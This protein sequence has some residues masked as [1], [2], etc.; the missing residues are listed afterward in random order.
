MVNS[1]CLRKG[2]ARR[3]MA[4][5]M[6]LCVLMG[7][8]PSALSAESVGNSPDSLTRSE[9]KYFVQVP[10]SGAVFFTG[11]TYGTGTQVTVAAGT[12][13]Q[14]VTDNYY[15]V[16]DASNV[17]T[18]YYGVFY[19]NVQ[20]QVRCSDVS[21]LSEEQLTTYIENFIWKAGTHSTLKQELNLV[22]DVRVYALQLALKQLGYYSSILDGDYGQKTD[23]AVY[24]FQR[25]AKLSRDGDAGPITQAALYSQVLNASGGSGSTGSGSSGNNSGS[26]SSGSGSS[27]SGSTGS[28]GSGSSGSSANT[29]TLVTVASVNLREKASKDSPRL[30]VV[31]TNTS[32]PYFDTSSSGNV[33]WYKVVYEEQIGWL[34]GTFV[35]ATGSNGSTGGG[36]GSGSGSGSSSTVPGNSLKTTDSV[37][38]RKTPSTSAAKLDVIPKGV[39]LAYTEVKNVNNVNWY[40]VTYGKNTGWIMGT[41]TSMGS[42]STGGSGSGSGSAGTDSTT[43]TGKVTITKKGTVVRLTPG[44]K[45]S[46]TLLSIGSVVDMLGSPVTS[47]SY[48]WYKIKLSNG[49]IGYVRG[50]CAKITNTGNTVPSGNGPATSKKFITLP[51]ATDLYLT[52]GAADGMVS[53]PA[54]S[55][56]MMVDVKPYTGNDGVEYC[57]LYY[58]GKAYHVEYARVSAGLMDDKALAAHVMGIWN[59]PLNDKF[60]NDG[61]LVGDVRVFAMQVALRVLGYYTGELDG[62]YGSGSEAAV[63]NFQRKKKVERDGVMGDQTWPLLTAQAKQVSDGSTTYSPNGDS[64]SGSG[65]VT[66]PD[67]GTV[68]KVK[69]ASWD[70]DDNGAQLFPKSTTATVMD[71]ETGKVFTIYRWSGGNHADCVPL[72]TADTQIMC[73]IAGAK[74]QSQKPTSAQLQKIKNDIIN[75]NANYCW[76]DFN[77]N[78]GGTNIGSAWDR[79]AA[80]LNVNGTVYCVSIYGYPHGWMDIKNGQPVASSFTNRKFEEKNN[81]YGM[82]CIHFVGSKTHGGSAVDSAHNNAINKAYSEAKKRWGNLVE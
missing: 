7:L 15:S 8:V 65:S 38:L 22:G 20:Y 69:K 4:L 56:L 3:L 73:E 61:S 1:S 55:V 36:S 76:P 31:P 12:V 16:T 44:G 54:G 2:M 74:Y 72:G 28:S 19:D 50:D 71:V 43:V 14:L 64:G 81:F 46:G 30:A 47:G 9:K 75:D 5:A 29:G 34:M 51:Q 6:V 11:A 62:S 13:C 67:F 49:L 78:M 82:I 68:Y 17:T 41:Y 18:T 21:V 37:N 40:K 53:V 45:R 25:A 57:M 52:V 70:Y 10:A 27:G 77:G 48:T 32:L 79:R 80:W 26:G 60:Y 24:R 33:T 39:T 63:R 59:Q 66:E 23:D 42:G 58:Q 35:K